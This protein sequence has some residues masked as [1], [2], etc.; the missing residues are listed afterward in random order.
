MFIDEQRETVVVGGGE[1]PSKHYKSL[2]AL[3]KLKE[4]ALVLCLLLWPLG[5][6]AIRRETWISRSRRSG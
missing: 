2:K 3:I 4:V 1:K 6:V 5:N